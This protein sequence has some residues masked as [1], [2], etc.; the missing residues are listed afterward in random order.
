MSANLNVVLLFINDSFDTIFPFIDNNSSILNPFVLKIAPSILDT[1]TIVGILRKFLSNFLLFCH[2]IR[3]T[4][5]FTDPKPSKIK[6]P[7][8]LHF[9]E[10]MCYEIISYFFSLKKNS[11]KR[12]LEDETKKMSTFI[13]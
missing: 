4:C 6:R 10:F 7:L 3:H 1:P 11:N 8:L 2:N 12:S 5:W 13:N 9:D